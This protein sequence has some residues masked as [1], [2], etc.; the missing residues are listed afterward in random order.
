MSQRT[1]IDL[2]QISHAVGSHAYTS[3]GRCFVD[4]ISGF[5]AAFLGHCHPHV[6][7]KLQEQLARIWIT[8]RYPSPA[9]ME[10]DARIRAILPAGLLPGGVYSTGMEAAGFAV[11][12]AASHTGRREFVGFARSMHGKSAMTAALCWDNAPVRSELAHT[13]PFAAGG[14]EDEV[15]DRLSQV[16]RRHRVAAVFIEPIQ[17]SNGAHE[18]SI[19][20]L[21]C[22]I[23]L[24]R[25]HGTL[26]IFDEIL[27]GLYRTGTAFYADRLDVKPDLLLFAKSM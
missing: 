9:T 6:T 12:L 5:G 26:T 24:A 25:E 18:T 4:L 7:H 8:G 27:T 2:P 3:D 13:L 10:A 21:E 15:L 22:V 14:C 1:D 11:R 23:A 19:R 17:G 16:L 20:F